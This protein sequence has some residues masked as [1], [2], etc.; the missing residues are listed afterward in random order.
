MLELFYMGGPLFMGILTIILIAMIVVAV[1][2][3]KGV[4]DNEID[5]EVAGRKIA[6]VK[7]VGL[8]A[9]IVGFL[10][11]LIGLFSAF[12]AIELKAVE[13]S[14]AILASG[15]KVSMISTVYGIIIYAL[16]FMIWFGL[17]VVLEKKS[18]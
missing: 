8:F 5:A 12:R 1:I 11:Q 15:F 4:F 10:G 3:G 18:N 2:N 17:S 16:S 13:V 6:Y 9:L 7:S 14:P